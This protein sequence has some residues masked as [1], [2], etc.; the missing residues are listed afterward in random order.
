MEST[1]LEEETSEEQQLLAVEKILREMEHT[2]QVLLGWNAYWWETYQ[3]AVLDEEYFDKQSWEIVD[4]EELKIDKTTAA[5]WYRGI[6]LRHMLLGGKYNCDIATIVW[7]DITTK[8]QSRKI[9]FDNSGDITLEKR[10]RKRLKQNKTQTEYKAIYNTLSDD[11]SFDIDVISLLRKIEKTEKLQVSVKGAFVYIAYNDI[12]IVTDLKTGLKQV[13]ITSKNKEQNNSSVDF[14]ATLREDGALDSSD[15]TI[16]THKGNGKVNGT[17]KFKLSS[18]KGI[19]ANFYSRKGVKIDL[20]TNPMLLE[21]AHTM[22]LPSAEDKS[23]ISGTSVIRTFATQSQ[24]AIAESLSERTISF[25]TDKFNMQA[26]MNAQDLVIETLKE[27]KGEI[28][29]QGLAERIDKVLLMLEKHKTGQ[30]SDE[31]KT[32]KLK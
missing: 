25:D 2:E 6:P 5:D 1:F 30:V 18:Q 24:Q 9:V 8:K 19:Q 23:L 31:A 27:I 13:N 10:N 11:F 28:P 16:N 20:T 14:T 12:K 4:E 21:K 22:M 32:L 15:I 7:D 29:L 3:N 26:V 17:Y